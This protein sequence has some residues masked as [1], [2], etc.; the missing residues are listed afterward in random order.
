MVVGHGARQRSVPLRAVIVG[1]PWRTEVLARPVRGTSV[2]GNRSTITGNPD[3]YRWVHGIAD[4]RTRRNRALGRTVGV[5]EAPALP[6]PTFIFVIA[7]ALEEPG[8]PVTSAPDLTVPTLAPQ[9]A[10]PDG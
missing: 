4:T 10:C 9:P 3:P 6:R 7:L 8:S 5:C 1:T 2:V